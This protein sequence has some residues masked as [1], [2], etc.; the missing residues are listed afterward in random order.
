MKQLTKNLLTAISINFFIFASAYSDSNIE[1]PSDY[2][3][4]T[5]VKSMVIHEGHPLHSSFGG[6]H[7]IYAN[8][9]ALVGYQTGTFPEGSIIIFDLLAISDSDNSITEKD[10]KVLG[11]MMKDSERFLETS[12]WG[13]EGF[14][15]GD[16]NNTVVGDNYKE[17]CY[18]C[19]TSQQEKDYVFSEWKD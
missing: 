3:H 18:Q 8:K 1:Y 11:V 5:H 13:F 14:G 15:S 16:A 9:P 12:G 10:R 2:R 4:W 7:R 19:H 6:I 17:A